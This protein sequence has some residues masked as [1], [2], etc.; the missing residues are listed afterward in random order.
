MFCLSILVNHVPKR[1]EIGEPPVA[2]EDAVGPGQFKG[3]HLEGPKRERGIGLQ[4]GSQAE[5]PCCLDDVFQAD[6]RGKIDR[7]RVERKFQRRSHRDFPVVFAVIVARRP[8]FPFDDISVWRVGDDCGGGDIVEGREV[9]EGFEEGARLAVSVHGPVE[10]GFRVVSPSDHGEDFPR[11]GLNDDHRR[12][13]GF[14]GPFE[15]GPPL[16]EFF[17]S[18]SH[19]LGCRLL[20][21]RSKGGEDP[22]TTAG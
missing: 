2:G 16:F 15:G 10:R 3:R 17:Q 7:G 18:A 5:V 1:E 11:F 8:G 12:L 13:E 14:A 21:F 9:D 6:S 22:K 19:G 4:S 20:E